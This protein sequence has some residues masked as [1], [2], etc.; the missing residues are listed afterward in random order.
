MDGAIIADAYL[1]VNAVSDATDGEAN[2]YLDESCFFNNQVG[3]KVGPYTGTMD[4]HIIACRFAAPSLISPL[5]GMGDFGIYLNQVKPTDPFLIGDNLQYQAV[6]AHNE[7]DNLDVA[8][9]S[10]R[11]DAK[12]VDNFFHDVNTGVEATGTTSYNVSLSVGRLLEPLEED[13]TIFNLFTNVVTAI[14]VSN[15]VITHAYRNWLESDYNEGRVNI[16]WTEGLKYQPTVLK[17]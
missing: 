4:S 6:S 17:L 5:S 8:I 12:I 13:H 2:I 7:F 14:D 3:V 11:S 15:H 9:K 10:Y 16:L 1:A